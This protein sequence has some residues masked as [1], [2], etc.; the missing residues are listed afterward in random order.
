MQHQ[1]QKQT[2]TSLKCVLKRPTLGE[3]NNK[4]TSYALETSKW[5][6]R[7]WIPPDVA[8]LSLKPAYFQQS[9]KLFPPT[10]ESL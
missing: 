2:Y 4:K 7:G 3:N 6:L 8:V 5:L 9:L 10:E 1:F